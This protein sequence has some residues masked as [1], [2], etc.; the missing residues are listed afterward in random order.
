MPSRLIRSRHLRVGRSKAGLGLFS[1][2]PIRKG[3][4]IIRYSGR[5]IRYR[6]GR[7]AQHQVSVRAQH[8]LDHRRRQ[9]AEHRAL[10][11]PRLPAQ[12]GDV[13]C[14]ARHQ[15][16]GDQEHQGRCRDHLPLRSQL[17]RRLHQGQRLH[18]RA[19]HEEANGSAK[20][21]PTKTPGRPVNRFPPQ[22]GCHPGQARPATPGAREPGSSNPGEREMSRRCGVLDSGSRDPGETRV[23][24]AGMTVEDASI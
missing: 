1:R 19:L 13:F 11:Q 12:C 4:F 16:P 10:H 23:A 15:D 3:Q 20:L 6:H 7:R 5:R 17:F 24:S 18:L 22:M 21:H 8:P 14:R 2:V 9:P